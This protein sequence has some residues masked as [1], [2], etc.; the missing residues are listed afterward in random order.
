MQSAARVAFPGL[1]WLCCLGPERRLSSPCLQTFLN[2]SNSSLDLW[3]RTL[4]NSVLRSCER[5]TGFPARS[6][7]PAAARFN[8]KSTTCTPGHYP[9]TSTRPRRISTRSVIDCPRFNRLHPISL[10]VVDRRS[11]FRPLLFASTTLRSQQKFVSASVTANNRTIAPA[12]VG[13]F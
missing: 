7:P 2:L 9:S 1:L 12:S 4:R 5:R 3:A 13:K 8:N 10:H 11:P 6:K